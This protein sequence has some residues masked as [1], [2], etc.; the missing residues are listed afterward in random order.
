MNRKIRHACGALGAAAVLAAGPAAALQLY[1]GGEYQIRLDTTI[2]HGMM[3]RVEKRD[4][5]IIGAANGG[6]AYSLNGDDGN[7]NFDRGLVS[8]VSR[9]T[10]EL[11]IRG[12]QGGAFLRGTAFYDWEI[13][14]RDRDNLSEEVEDTVGRDADLLDAYLWGKGTVGGRPVQLR[15]GEQVVS[16]GESTFITNGINILNPVNVGAIRQPGAELKDALLPEG[17]AWGSLGLSENLSLEG[18]FIWHW[19]PTEIDPAGSYFSS[20]DIVGEGGQK[21]M[22]GFG[23]YADGGLAPAPYVFQAVP[24]GPTRKADDYGQWGS[25]LRLFAPGLNDT[26]FGFYFVNYHS[27]LP[28][29]SSRTGTAAGV[30]AAGNVSAGAASMAGTYG[31]TVAPLLL[32]GDPGAVDT[33][34][35]AAIID[36]KSRGMTD[37]QAGFIANALAGRLRDGRG[38]PVTVPAAT[39]AAATDAYAKTG[40]YFTEYPED[41]KLF[42][43]SF[44]TLLG[45]TGIALQGEASHRRDVPLQIDDLEL[46]FAT[47]GGLNADL[48][49]KNQIEN[50]YMKLGHEVTGYIL[51]NMTQLQTTA[52]K[53]FGPRLGTDQSVLLGEVGWTYVHDMPSKDEMRLEV[54]GT[55]ISGNQDLAY[56]HGF[57]ASPPGQPGKYEPASAFADASSWG[58]RLA[59]RMDFNN[60]FGLV[61]LFPRVAWSHDVNGNTPG[62]GGNFLEGRRALTL[63]LAGTYQNAWSADLSYTSFLGAGR[64]NL[65]NDRDF[66]AANLKYSF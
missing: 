35:A 37:D 21:V 17:M 2:S 4:N 42:G 10:P 7:L 14:E 52:T 47:L 40:Y 31:S 46:L 36:G 29:I 43:V 25:A 61:N 58:Y 44:N 11:E 62:P 59:Y 54:P 38:N 57:L 23:Y 60:V 51:K 32:A 18:V 24:R 50:T 15:A 20:S 55:Y 49:D 63:G 65:I 16:W 41:I 3:W 64:Q 5:D 28:V 9:I 33:A 12:R 13:M 53:A 8:N 6:R 56:T 48:A 34:M 26:E 30:L 27:R 19:E 1:S 66:V 45:G 39:A 22:L